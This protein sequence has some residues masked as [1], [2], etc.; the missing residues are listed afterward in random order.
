MGRAA[1]QLSLLFGGIEEPEAVLKAPPVS[2]FCPKLQ[3]ILGFLQL[4][5]K[6]YDIADFNVAWNSRAE[7]TFS[8]VLGPAM[9]RSRPFD[10][11]T[12]VQGIPRM[13]SW[14]GPWMLFVLRHNSKTLSQRAQ[15]TG[16]TGELLATQFLDGPTGMLTEDGI[17]ILIELD[18]ADEVSLIDGQQ[19]GKQ[20]HRA[21]QRLDLCAAA[22]RRTSHAL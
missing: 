14:Q 10:N 16:F 22:L 6:L 1:D 18:R 17:G 11:N 20:A 5:F 12:K 2:D 4:K 9:Q 13:S 8:N 19:I 21:P 7:P 15:K 3:R